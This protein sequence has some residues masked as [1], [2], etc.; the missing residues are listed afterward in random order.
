MSQQ[1]KAVQIVLS[2]GFD[3]LGPRTAKFE[4]HNEYFPEN[5]IIIPKIPAEHLTRYYPSNLIKP[6]VISDLQ[7]PT[8]VEQV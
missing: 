3:M 8:E 5:A 4:L 2:E 7:Q 6:T 1:R